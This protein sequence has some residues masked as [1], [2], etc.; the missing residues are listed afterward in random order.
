MVSFNIDTILSRKMQGFFRVPSREKPGNRRI[1]KG[2]GQMEGRTRKQLQGIVNSKNIHKSFPNILEITLLYKNG[3]I[4]SLFYFN[5]FIKILF[6]VL[7]SENKD[8]NIRL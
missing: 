4:E 2:N 1:Y 8:V 5:F 6:F 3:F 7:T